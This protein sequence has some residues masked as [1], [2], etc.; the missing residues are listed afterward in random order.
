MKEK[1]K[2][3]SK[4]RE[5]AKKPPKVRL[6][7][8]AR[9]LEVAT[10]DRKLCQECGLFN[11]K[12][13]KNPFLLPKVPESWDKSYLLIGSAPNNIED[14]KGRLGIGEPYK[15]LKQLRKKA[16]ISKNSVAF[17]DAVRCG[18]PYLKPPTSAQVRACRPFLLQ[19]IDDLK[20]RNV[21]LLGR[22]AITA[23]RNRAGLSVIQARGKSIPIVG[24]KR[25]VVGYATYHP[26]AVEQGGVHLRDVILS[27]LQRK[28]QE[29][30]EVPKNSTPVTKNVIGFDVEYAPDKTLLTIGLASDKAAKAWDCSA[31]SAENKALIRRT[32]SL[33][34]HNVAG[35]LDYL[36]QNKIVKNSW[37][38]G[39]DLMDSLLLARLHD[40]T[41]E[42]GGYGLENLLCSEFQVEQWKEPTA[43]QF[44]KHPD[45]SLWTP[46]DRMERCRIDAWAS[47]K[48]AS[49]Y[50]DDREDLINISH[51]IEMTLYRVGLAGATVLNSRFRRLGNE[52]QA[53]ATRYGDLVTRAAFKTGMTVFEPTN[54]N[55]LRELLFE[56]LHL[57]KRGY[58]KKSHEAQ[59][60]KEVLKETLKLTSKRWK[61][62]IIKNILAFS[63]N[64]KLATICFGGKSKKE[65]IKA[66]K[67][68]FPKNSKLAL[69]PFRINSL[70]AKTGRRSSGG[71]DEI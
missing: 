33:V 59:V 32:T 18:T 27:D 66:L 24:T 41:K 2:K 49:L 10:P 11:R 19:T 21:V 14:K 30:L 16:G 35:D 45:A 28:D 61:R 60:D 40:E 55:H 39:D 44:K 43:T 54:K 71:K 20:P 4:V 29:K 62:K 7:L 25:D 58:T 22:T 34:G 46:H 3:L 1:T 68:S 6:E 38:R 23:A 15:L 69:L 67:T 57:K 64:N 70:G 42:R 50:H 12:G 56:R 26:E 48:L 47:V 17:V 13:T 51:R 8:I 31:I 37:L 5:K 9:P 36:A 65:S 63:E 53:D 52:W